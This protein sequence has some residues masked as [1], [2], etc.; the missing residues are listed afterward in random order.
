M[1]RPGTTGLVVLG[2]KT[3][4]SFT[5]YR[6]RRPDT[7]HITSF[8]SF[9]STASRHDPHGG[10]TTTPSRLRRR[11]RVPFPSSGTNGAHMFF[12]S[13]ALVEESLEGG[14]G[15]SLT[16]VRDTGRSPRCRSIPVRPSVDTNFT[17]IPGPHITRRVL[18]PKPS[19][20]QNGDF[21]TF[22]C[23]G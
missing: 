21:E 17:T 2:Y 7:T 10:P 11:R 23:R 18:S 4:L 20:S 22:R 16:G 15:A 14:P 3:F 6:S 13:P 5:V 9:Q 12:G 19:R 1:T 8:T